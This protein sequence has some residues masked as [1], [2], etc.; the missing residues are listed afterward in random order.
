MIPFCCLF[1]FLNATL[2]PFGGWSIIPSY[3]YPFRS[4]ND[5]YAVTDNFFTT[6]PHMIRLAEHYFP[7][8]EQKN[9]RH[10]VWLLYNEV[11]REGVHTKPSHALRNKIP[12]KPFSC[13]IIFIKHIFLM[14]TSRCQN[15]FRVVFTYERLAECT[16]CFYFQRYTFPHT[17]LHRGTVQPQ[18]SVYHCDKVQPPRGGKHVWRFASWRLPVVCSSLNLQQT[19]PALHSVFCLQPVKPRK[20]S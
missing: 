8:H 9:A 16:C 5:I 11:L 13:E 19:A 20:S 12:L 3:V 17:G 4:L 2:R 7:T 18:A 15:I 1:S 14:P 6:P 10:H